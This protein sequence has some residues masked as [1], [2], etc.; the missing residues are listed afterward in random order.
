LRKACHP[1]T[2]SLRQLVLITDF[3]TGHIGRPVPVPLQSKW[4]IDWAPAVKRARNSHCVGEGRP[5]TKA[6]T[7]CI[8]SDPHNCVS[9]YSHVYYS[10]NATSGSLNWTWS[11]LH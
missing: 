4:V 9:R 10:F 5:N 7:T 6:N 8:Q 3:G 1:G 11:S 2:N